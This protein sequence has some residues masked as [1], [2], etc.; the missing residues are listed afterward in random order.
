MRK[1]A[2][3]IILGLLTGQMAKAQL[4]INELM[5]SNVDCVMDDLNEL[6]DS[7]VEL[8]NAGNEDIALK[9]YRVG[10]SDQSGEAWQLPDAILFPKE[11]ALVYCDKEATIM[12][13]HFRL[14][15]GKDCN[16]YLFKGSEIVDKVTGLPK[17]PAPD[18]AYGRKV[19]GGNEWGYQLYPTPRAAN[20]G[21]TTDKILGDPLFS[22]QGRVVAEG[23]SLSLTL[24]LPEGSPEGAQIRFTIDGSEPTNESYRYREPLEITSTVIIRAKLFCD[25]WLSPRSVT[26]SYIFF[27]RE[28]TLPVISISTDTKYLASSQIG[29]YVEGNYRPGY[30]NYE[31]KWR[32]PMN[33]EF[34][35]GANKA[36]VINQLCEAR[37][38]GESSRKY[39]PKSMIFY[40]HKRFG[41]KHFKYEFFPD[42][43]PGL[44][45]Q[46]SIL[47]R[48]AGGDNP[49]LYLR[50]ALIQRVMGTYTDIDWQPWRPA[51]IYLNGTY[52]GIINIRE[53][54]T[55]DY[56]WANYDGLEDIDM[57]E[58]WA[59]EDDER[60]N[61][62]CVKEGDRENLNKFKAFYKQRG[63]TREEYE[64]WM[65]CV[66]FINL[67]VMNLYFG[68]K[69]FPGNNTLMWRPRAEGGR[70]RFVAKDVDWGLGHEQWAYPN[71]LP[72]RCPAYVNMI[73]YITNYMVGDYWPNKPKYTVLFRYMMENRDLNRQFV[74][75]CSIYMGDFLNE[76]GVRAIWDPMYEMI[77]TEHS[78]HRQLYPVERDFD[79][80][81]ADARRWISER[82]NYFY[83]HLAS[84]YNLG[85]PIP[86]TINQSV[87]KAS[88]MTVRFNDVKL[89]RGTFDGKFFKN[90]TVTLEGD[91]PEGKEITGWQVVIKYDSGTKE[92]FVEGTRCSF[93]MPS[94]N[95]VTINAVLVDVSGVN[96][97]SAPDW[98]WQ[99]DGNRLILSSVPIGTKVQ[100][101]DLRGML[102]N[103]V[104]SEG[105]EII[106]PLSSSQF[107]VLRVGDKTI[108]F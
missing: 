17:Q 14:E 32:R 96:T 23:S 29:I 16:V 82:T 5:Q 21:E 44:V 68:N 48:N 65:D 97:L 74:D 1:T 79:T 84:S 37:I 70:W 27:P 3:L 8:Y 11:Y 61:Q 107:H 51:I 49:Y 40:A 76:K 90:H 66:E 58:N 26:H 88:E 33:I 38:M 6:P 22:E 89:S 81:L 10:I 35:E 80:E 95:S 85:S 4:V 34:F 94:C 108:K 55:A 101:Y 62:E 50:D 45:E 24:S 75:R 86:M 41:T 2:F 39:I 36:S 69:D 56:V 25:G 106:L 19:D 91:A 100:L 59:D 31:F 60:I 20:C 18:I 52:L 99:H 72:N 64:K 47:L 54:S 93:D 46:K 7:W 13:T 15:S 63:H 87:E 53:R 30:K 78:Y 104:V 102:I 71:P 9:N 103:T 73:D 98:K 105:T 42:Q 92:N 12:H 57:I 67:M 43:K 28:V 83:N 77:K